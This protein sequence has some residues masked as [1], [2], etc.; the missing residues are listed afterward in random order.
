MSYDY[1]RSEKDLKESNL[2]SPKKLANILEGYLSPVVK[3]PAERASAS[4]SSFKRFNS[5]QT[6]QYLEDQIK[7][8]K[9]EEKY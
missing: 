4:N 9:N 2:N 3:V 7:G 1:S 5:G 6:K 8:C